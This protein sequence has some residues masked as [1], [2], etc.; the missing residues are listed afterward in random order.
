MS[1]AQLGILVQQLRKLAAVPSIG[2]VTD[3]Q[4]LDEFLSR[5]DEAAFTELVRRHGP[6]VL[7]V[8]QS[9]L[10]NRHD[11]E[12]VFQ[13]AFLIL[14]RK[15][16]SIR[17]REAV[18]G[19]L[20]EVAYRLAL[21]EQT[22]IARRRTQG[23]RREAP[24]VNDPLL[25]MTLR[26]L[27]QVLL[28][29]LQRLPERYRLPLVLC[30][31]EDRT[32]AE[33]ARQLG[34]AKD[35]LRGRLNRGRC[36]L[37]ARLVRRG[38]ALS[39]SVFLSALTGGS[40]LR[41]LPAVHVETTVKAALAPAIARDVGMVSERV[42]VLVEGTTR[43]LFASHGK[44]ITLLVLTMG[45]L[46]A[47]AAV[48]VKCQ[49]D[50]QAPKASAEQ[51]A[52][53]PPASKDVPAKAKPEFIFEDKGDSIAVS[54]RVLDPDGKPFAGAE[55]TM[56]WQEDRGWFAY[57]DSAMHDAKP[58]RGAVSGGDG[59]F[60]FT[61]AK[62]AITNTLYTG[63]GKPWNW[64]VLVAAARGYGPAWLHVFHLQEPGRKLQLVRDDVPIVGRIR[65]LQGRPVAGA[66]V[67]LGVVKTLPHDPYDTLRQDAWSGLTLPV[68]TDKDGRFRVTGIGRNRLAKLIVSGPG[69]ETKVVEVTTRKIVDGKPVE[70]STLDLLVGPTK[71]IEGTVRAKDTGKPLAGVWIYGNERDFCNGQ[72]VGGRPIRAVTDDKGRYRLL[73][74]PK[75]GHYELTIFPA[76]RQSYLC[77]V[78][79]VAD[80]EGLKPITADIVLRR[81]VPIRVRLLDK[82]TRQPVRGDIRYEL[83]KD[84]HLWSEAV[85][86]SGLINSR[87]F[88]LVRPTDQDGYVRFVAYPGPG[89][90]FASG[91]W[92]YE[93][94]PFLPA[95]LNPADK[96]KG[97]FPLTAG[98]PTNGF[99]E[100][101]NAYRRIDPAENDKEL[102]FDLYVDSGRKVLGRL[103]GP[104]FQPVAG[105]IAHGLR[106]GRTA[107]RLPKP[108]DELVKTETFVAV[109]LDPHSPCTLSFVHT[110]RK[111]IGHAIVRGDEKQPL[112]VRLQPWGILTGRL[113]DGEGTP[114]ADVHLGLKYP[115]LPEPGMRPW[116]KEVRTGRDGRFRV[117]GLLPNLKHDLILAS[118]PAK[119]V[120]L[121]AGDRI[122]DLSAR[123]GEVKDLG[124]ILVEQ[125]IK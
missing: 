99:L 45:L 51:P 59:R 105:A 94:A 21:K 73:G 114:L 3:R 44:I 50:T 104:D 37:R 29:E 96:A 49:L 63:M 60:R 54:G 39:A 19:W 47:T 116:D 41:A 84:N 8:C 6:M 98:D 125:A 93:A 17:H 32:Q 83:G 95:R 71:P 28:Q 100:F 91:G 38:L 25:D 111:L 11:A 81:G 7:G 92:D 86:R 79:S 12:D 55:V 56:W 90:I 10:H 109:G 77:T 113:V 43:T 69:I 107:N 31:L 40:A 80:N 124:D 75:A 64:A 106:F 15:A 53:A 34:W 87:E 72:D 58:Y 118:D 36:Q 26:E 88:Y 18:G 112:T 14:A 89:V 13:A 108:Q 70:Q 67:R 35:V 16:S 117:E 22:A 121:S 119:K 2:L 1:S 42:A 123:A 46:T 76:T 102:T 110:E 120:T 5:R 52:E 85:E 23:E 103:I 61:L 24:A 9:V 62:S 97:H 27:H 30:Y 65:D 78:R 82:Q 68:T 115:D 66:T 57:H 20:C 48:W 101:F 74:L 4:L 33:A 122:K